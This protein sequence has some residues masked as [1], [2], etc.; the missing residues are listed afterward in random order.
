MDCSTPGFSVRHQFLEFTQTHVHWVSDAIQPSHPLLSPSSPAFNLSQHQ[1]LFKWVSSSHQVVKILEFQLQHQSF[2]WIDSG[3]TS[4][5]MDW[6]DLQHHS[7]K[8]SHPS[9]LWAPQ[10]LSSDLGTLCLAACPWDVTGGAE[11]RSRAHPFISQRASTRAVLVGAAALW[12]SQ[13]SP[14]LPPYTLQYVAII[15]VVLPGYRR[16]ILHQP[17]FQEKEKGCTSFPSNP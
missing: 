13:G 15:N 16:G 14:L 2:Q 4:F 17:E 7:I 11:P 12:C 9:V 8:P 6:L 10:A 5:R 3:L 1:G